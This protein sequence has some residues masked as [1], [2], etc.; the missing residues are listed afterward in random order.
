M[1]LL[2]CQLYFKRVE[3]NSNFSMVVVLLTNKYDSPC[4]QECLYFIPSS[5]FFC[6]T[7]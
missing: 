3:Y 1:E 7:P 4:I 5:K 6:H 2:N